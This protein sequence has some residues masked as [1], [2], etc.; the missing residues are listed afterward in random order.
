MTSTPL[1][2]TFADGADHPAVHATLASLPKHYRHAGPGAG[3]VTAVTTLAALRTALDARPSGILLTAATA[4]SAGTVRELA[5][6]AHAA[7]IP[8]VVAGPWA[9]DPA[10]TA[11]AGTLDVEGASLIEVTATV[12]PGRTSADVLLDQLA[13][14]RTAIAPARAVEVT[15]ADGHGHLARAQV[16]DVPVHLSAA[17]SG[18]GTRRARLDVLGPAVQWRLTFADPAT[19]APATVVRTDAEGEHLFPTV[20]ES[21]YRAAWR[22]LHAAVTGGAVPPYSLHDLADDLALLAP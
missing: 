20:Y 11:V 9:L 8:V 4:D 22:H 5:E 2:V 18:L 3:A 10:V 15:Q 1:A 21:A 14:L 13:L 12:P 6:R 16:G 19:A 7:G 17:V